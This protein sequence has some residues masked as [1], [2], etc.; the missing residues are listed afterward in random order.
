[1]GEHDRQDA[2]IAQNPSALGEDRRHLRLVVGVGQLFAAG[3]ELRE[4]GGVGYGLVLFVGQLGF[5]EV[6]MNQP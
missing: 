4:A 1:V 5:E 6:G 3:A 2:V